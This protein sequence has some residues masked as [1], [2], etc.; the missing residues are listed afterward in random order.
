MTQPIEGETRTFERTFTVEDVQQF[1]ALSGD[2][3]P[4]HTEPDEDGRVMVQGLLTATLPTKM[5]SD[6]EVLA[7]TMEFNFHQPVYTGES[8]TCRS[9]Y[10]TVVE[11]A[12]RYEFTSDVVCENEAG[13]TVLT[14]TTEGIILKDA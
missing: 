7:S 11:R 13:E 12:D 9:T 14:A 8:I 5:G 1:A 6:A 2:D 10:D 4:R 3:Q